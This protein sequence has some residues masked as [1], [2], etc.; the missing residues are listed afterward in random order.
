MTILSD[1]AIG[2]PE[3]FL[4]V[5]GMVMLMI[6][7]FRREPSGSLVAWLAIAS[8]VVAAFLVLI[9]SSGPT[10]AFNSLFVVDGFA[11]YAKILVLLGAALT[12]LLAV[13]YNERARINK[14]EFSVLIVY[15][16]VGMLMMVSANDLISV[17]MGIELQ[18]L[19]LYVIAAFRRDTLRSS[20]AG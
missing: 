19:S 15:A 11:V 18:S 5:A 10:I 2:L 4:A 17:Y 12:L 13:S 14:F 8:F 16:V 6:G 3:I 9:G 1:I 7:A 20:E